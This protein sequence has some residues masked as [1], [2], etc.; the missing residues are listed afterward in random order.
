MWMKQILDQVTVDIQVWTV[1]IFII[2]RATDLI[3]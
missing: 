3:K 2:I 1:L